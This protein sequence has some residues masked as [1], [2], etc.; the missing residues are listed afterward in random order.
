V[1]E[2]LRI[3][4][5]TAPLLRGVLSFRVGLDPGVRAQA[6]SVLLR[7]HEDPAGRGA[8]QQASGITR[9]DPLTAAERESL[10]GWSSVLRP[11]P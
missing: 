1:R 7:L 2:R 10:R 8:L 4:H 9:L 5:E 11:E 6:L 3:F